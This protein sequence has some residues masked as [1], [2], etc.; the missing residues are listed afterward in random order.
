MP[1]RDWSTGDQPTE[2]EFDTLQ[3]Q[4]INTFPDESTR[5]SEIVLA[6]RVD[7]MVTFQEDTGEY[8]AWNDL[9][10]DWVRNGRIRAW[11]TYTPVLTATGSDPDLGSG[12]V[13]F[14]RW[15]KEGTHATVAVFLKFGSSGSSAGSGNYEISLPSECPVNSDWFG[16]IE[17]IAGNGLSIDDSTNTRKQVAVKIVNT[18]VIRLESDGLT[19][20][21]TEA[22]LIAWANNDI[23]LS[24][25]FE[26]ETE[27]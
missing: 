17:L 5:D 14:G 13:Q 4:G 7:G 16:P 11:G 24:A 12:P 26:Y 15:F 25:T 23:V 19:G 27:E 10:G 18:S 21:V 1:Y 3:R 20:V 22:N 9:I 2:G 6:D 8:T